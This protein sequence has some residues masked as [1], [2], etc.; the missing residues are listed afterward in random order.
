MSEAVRVG[1]LS[2]IVIQKK[3]RPIGRA[4]NQKKSFTY[5]L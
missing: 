4:S 2:K 3:A 1:V 5:V